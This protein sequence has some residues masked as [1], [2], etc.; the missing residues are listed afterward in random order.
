MGARVS[1]SVPAAKPHAG[2]LTPTQVVAAGCVPLVATKLS[3]VVV[4]AAK[5][6][7]VAEVVPPAYWA[8]ST[9]PLS[10]HS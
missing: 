1:V 5:P 4:P 6:L 3:A 9:G 7:N 8:T 10:I 2:G